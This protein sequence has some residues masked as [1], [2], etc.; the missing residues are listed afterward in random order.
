MGLF[1]KATGALRHSPGI[2]LLHTWFSS[3]FLL[4]SQ[5]RETN[6]G[7]EVL[8]ENSTASAKSDIL[9]QSP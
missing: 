5:G 2:L 8:E 9:F 6:R 7:H 3:T 4:A 1:S